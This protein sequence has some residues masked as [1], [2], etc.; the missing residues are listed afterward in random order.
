[1]QLMIYFLLHSYYV[2]LKKSGAN[3]SKIIDN[4]IFNVFVKCFEGFEKISSWDIMDGAWIGVV[5]DHLS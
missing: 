2:D 1:M 4:D 5:V 3:Q